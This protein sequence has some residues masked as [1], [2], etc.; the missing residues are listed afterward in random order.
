MLLLTSG[1][2]PFLLPTTTTTTK[3]DQCVFSM[4]VCCSSS[5][6]WLMIDR[7][8]VA[9]ARVTK[10]VFLFSPFFAFSGVCSFVLPLPFFVCLFV[11]APGSVYTQ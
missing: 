10:A 8:K 6:A 11:H 1:F 7:T 2:I 3:T 4:L 5:D 9:F